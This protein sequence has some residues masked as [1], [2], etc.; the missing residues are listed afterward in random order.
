LEELMPIYHSQ[1]VLIGRATV[2]PSVAALTDELLF[3]IASVQKARSY[4]YIL[5]NCPREAVEPICRLLPG[6]KSPT[7]MPLADP[8][9][10]SLHSVVRESDFWTIVGQ[11][12][13]AGAEGILV[14][15]IEKMIG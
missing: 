14:L 2:Q 5:L 4:K 7:I 1:A 11:L 12:R 15:P 10:C 13:A 3:R 9:W 8:A 6:V